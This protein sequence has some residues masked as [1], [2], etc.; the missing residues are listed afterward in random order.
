MVGQKQ[1]RDG[2]EKER[3]KQGWGSGVARLLVMNL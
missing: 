2:K 3:E 1:R